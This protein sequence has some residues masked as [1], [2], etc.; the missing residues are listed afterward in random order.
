VTTPKN[1]ASKT[2]RLPLFFI[3][4]PVLI[5][6]V[7]VAGVLLWPKVD[8]KYP[9]LGMYVRDSLHSNPVDAVQGPIH[10]M[11]AFTD[12][13]EPDDQPTMDR[14]TKAYREMAAAYK[15]ADGRHPQ[16]SWFWFFAD[17][18]P[19][20]RPKFLNQLSGMAYEGLGEIEIHMHHDHNTSEQ[21]VEMMNKALEMTREQGSLIT[22]EPQPRK[23][24]A[25]IHGLWSL[26]N[27]RGKGACGVNNELI[28]LR[29]LGCYADFTNPSW[30]Q[31]HPHMVNRLYY[32]TDDPA[33]PKS[34]D[35]GQEAEVGKPGVGDLFEFTGQSVVHW[36]GIRPVYD[37]GEIEASELP[38]EE[39]IDSWIK[40]GVHV[41]GKPDWIFVKVFAHSNRAPDH[42]AVLGEWGRRMNKYLSTHYN[43]GQ[44]YVLHYVTAREAY[45]IAK[46]AEAGKSGNPNDYRDFLIKPYVN[47]Y[48]YSSVPYEAISVDESKA[49]LRFLAPEGAAVK[50]RVHGH[51]VAVTGDAEVTGTELK[52]DETVVSLTVR[53]SGLVGITYSGLNT[54][55]VR[56]T[57]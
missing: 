6:A 34:Y 54:T 52:T 25:F 21:F 40:K 56:E 15:D 42:E 20:E 12:H 8:A 28:L 29:Q 18:K 16:H 19:E 17:A 36:K 30:G 27:S 14:W 11:F 44:K 37:H 3:F 53:G 38:T 45:N 2:S 22:A 57:A 48:F 9:W 4:L 47:R 1:T 13:F 7:G 46:A 24:F 31:M 33:K 10:V 5:V 32:A 39:R 49:V 50:L 26:D 43:D 55:L 51:G 35:W 41:K 23:T